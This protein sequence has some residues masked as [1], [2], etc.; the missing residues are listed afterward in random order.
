M[1]K[2]LKTSQISSKLVQTCLNMFKLAKI[3]AKMNDNMTM[4]CML[5]SGLKITK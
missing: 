1:S 4:Y 3:F 5:D 2:F